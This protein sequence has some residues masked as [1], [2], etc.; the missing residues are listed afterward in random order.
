MALDGKTAIVTGAAGGI[1]YAIAERF[2]RE[3]VRV[4]IADVDAEKGAKAIKDLEKLGEVDFV[5]TDVGK[6]LDV[7][8]LVA[9][10]IDSLGDIDILVN[11]AGVVHG[12]DFLDL[13]EEDFDRVL[14]INLKGAFLVGQA[15]ARYMV[16]KVKGGG[17]PGVVINMSSVNAVF[18]I[19]NQVPYSVSK[20]GMNQLTKVMALSL[21]PHGIRVN[22]IGPGSIMTEMLASVNADPAARDR[23]LSRTPLGR[24]GDPREIASIAAFLASD[25]AS[26]ITGQT[27]YADGGRLPLNYTVEVQP[28]E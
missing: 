16:D 28:Q 4:V 15:V 18:A 20:G 9:S 24:I 3:G 12:A 10:T 11:N 8:N 5:K 27:I 13:K 23:I 22:A 1:G 6:S 26:Y 17:A 25:D 21:A 7:H 14:R 2:L 19:A